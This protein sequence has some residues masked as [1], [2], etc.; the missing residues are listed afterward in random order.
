MWK[1][2]SND[3]QLLPIHNH[4]KAW[5]PKFDPLSFIYKHMPYEKLPCTDGMTLAI[6]RIFMVINYVMNYTLAFLYLSSSGSANAQLPGC[7][8]PWT[9]SLNIGL[10]RLPLD[11]FVSCLHSPLGFSTGSSRLRN[12]LSLRCLVPWINHLPPV[13]WST[14]WKSSLKW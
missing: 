11:S 5:T 4:F 7:F 13:C 14:F 12:W 6:I 10:N 8:R 1:W 3:S 2:R 9:F